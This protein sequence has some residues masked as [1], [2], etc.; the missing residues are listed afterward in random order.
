MSKKISRRNFIVTSLATAAGVAGVDL[1]AKIADHYGLLAPDHQGIFGIGESLTYGAQRILMSQG[2]L[3]R[4]FGRGDISKVSPVN[5]GYPRYDPY[6]RLLAG[7]ICRLASLCGWVGG[8]PNSVL[9]HRSKAYA[10]PHSDH[11][12]KLRRRLVVHRRMDRGAAFLDSLP[13]RRK[14][15]GKVGGVLP[16]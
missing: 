15:E 7:Q 4:E 6:E 8:P 16:I 2:S 3:A 5:H 11:R 1:A 14:S 13:R 12:A 9:T 10:F